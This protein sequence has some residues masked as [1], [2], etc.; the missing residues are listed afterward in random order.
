MKKIIQLALFFVVIGVFAQQKFKTHPVKEG[1]TIYSIAKQYRVTPFSILQHNPE[2]KNVEDIKPN[3]ILVIPLDGVQIEETGEKAEEEQEVEPIGFTRHRVK[4]KETVFGI[5]QQYEI[6]EEQLKRYNKDLYSLSLKKGMVLQIPQYPKIDPEE[7]KELDFDT[8]QVQPKETRWSIAHKFG[9]SMDSLV[10]LNPE[11]P[12]NSTHLSVGQEL[13]VPRPKGDSLKEQQVVLYESYTVPKS[14][15]LF[16]VSQEYNIPADSIIRLNPQITEMG[17][18][19]EGMVLRLPKRSAQNEDVNTDNY[20]FYE[21]KPKQGMFRLTQELNTSRDSLLLF[22]PELENGVKVGMVLKLPKS[23]M[24]GL[25]VKNALVLDKFNLAD[26]ISVV[27][28]PN[29]LFM[30][31]FRLDRINFANTDRTESQV[32]RKDIGAAVG[33]YSGAL[34]AMDSLKR[35]GVSVDATF[36]DTQR[37]LATVRSFMETQTLFDVDAIVGPVDPSLVNEIAVRSVSSRVPVI[38]PFASSNEL[39]F[40]NLFYS[41]PKDEVLREN[42]LDYVEKIRKDEELIVIADANN[43]AA[44]DSILSRFPTARIAKMSADGSLHLVDFEAMLF[45]DKTHWVFVETKDANLAA[46]VISILNA[47]NSEELYTVRMFT[48]AYNNAFETED[49]SPVHLSNLQFAFTSGFKEPQRDTFTKAYQQKFGYYPDRYAVRGFDLTYD[50]LLK[51]SFKKNLFTASQYVGQ[52]EY[53]GN[54][55]DYI[56]QLNMGYY[57]QAA[58]ILQYEDLQ[59]VEV[60]EDDLKSNL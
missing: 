10:L 16:R 31:P 44:K 11:L 57:N 34:V 17:G 50:L 15:G 2:I 38:A 29:L 6:T 21:V 48:T 55:F 39:G 1:E 42:L 27:N 9:I 54:R 26:S 20:I 51:L 36:F 4:R 56:N 8:Y 49:I 30:L 5:T 3:T 18:L 45:E 35:M 59:I 47:A 14:I 40:E 25:E 19:K 23:K 60:K 28:K 13:K 43:Q 7:E 12:R 52:T 46:S 22:N 58:Y 53:S 33:F 37:D 41:M 32:K 24:N